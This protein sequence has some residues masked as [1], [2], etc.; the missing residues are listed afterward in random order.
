M[1]TAEETKELQNFAERLRAGMSHCGYVL[2]GTDGNGFSDFA[3]KYGVKAPVVSEWRKGDYK[4]QHSKVRA[5]AAE[6][7]C[8][9]DW[10]YYGEGKPPAWFSDKAQREI[11]QEAPADRPRRYAD[12]DVI[13]LQIGI[14]SLAALVLAN[15]PESAPAFLADIHQRIVDRRFGDPDDQGGLLQ[16]L[17]RIAREVPARAAAASR[18]KLQ[19]GSVPSKR[20]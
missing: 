20:R 8:S 9:A 15:A 1:P 12:G 6:F 14:Q 13:A 2:R 3:K 5:M 10:L 17:Q 7:G 18:Q 16:Q 19:R 4:P 11:A